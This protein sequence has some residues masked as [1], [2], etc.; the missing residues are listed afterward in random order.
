MPCRSSISIN[1]SNNKSSYS[2]AVLPN[3]LDLHELGY[4]NI[5]NNTV[6]KWHN[7]I[8]QYSIKLDCAF[9]KSIETL[10][11]RMLLLNTKRVKIMSNLF[12]TV[13]YRILR[14]L[15]LRHDAQACSRL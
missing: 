9:K 2:L 1:N 13:P 7:N 5:E 6:Y 10:R 3:E 8:V 11:Y 4:N 15:T 12:D 14:L